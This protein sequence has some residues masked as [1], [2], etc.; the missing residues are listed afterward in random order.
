MEVFEFLLE[1]SGFAVGQALLVSEFLVGEL[2]HAVGLF[3]L[4]S[5]QLELSLLRLPL[6]QLLQQFLF[7]QLQGSYFGFV[8]GVAGLYSFELGS[9]SLVFFKDVGNVLLFE[10][11]F[12]FKTSVVLFRLELEPSVGLTLRS[13]L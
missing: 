5:D 6:L 1:K 12:I 8:A 10:G 7:S 3:P 11:E 4:V 13:Q 2:K 9:G